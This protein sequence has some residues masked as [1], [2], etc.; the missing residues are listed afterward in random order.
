MNMN[1]NYLTTISRS[2]FDPNICI[3]GIIYISSFL[4]LKSL[5]AKIVNI[6]FS[7]RNL[8]ILGENTS[9]YCSQIIVVNVHATFFSKVHPVCHNIVNGIKPGCDSKKTDK[10]AADC[11][12]A[13]CWGVK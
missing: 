1:Y 5:Q 4:T 11:S 10:H 6:Y 8:Y 2:I 12:K 3:S 13:E 9:K 7:T